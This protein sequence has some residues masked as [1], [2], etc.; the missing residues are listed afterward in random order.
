MNK[1]E[2]F[3]TFVLNYQDMVYSTAVRLL[4]NSADAQDISQEVFIK[5]YEYFPQFQNITNIGG[6]LRRIT[7]NLSLNH[8]SRYRAKWRFFSEMVSEDSHD[9]FEIEY[10]GE[11]D[12]TPEQNEKRMIL[13]KLLMSLPA[14]QR[15]PLVLYHYEGLSYEEIA[16]Q[17]GVSL[18]KVKTDIH[19][20]REALRK[21]IQSRYGKEDGM[22]PQKVVVE[23]ENKTEHSGLCLRITDAPS[24]QPSLLKNSCYGC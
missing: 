2:Q 8:L 13:D 9:K 20:G 16:E 15:I 18:G 24:N 10:I 21:L 6:W 23:R 17:L 12:A 19:R 11:S 1:E 4:G 7:I 22:S 5:A 14:K 3:N